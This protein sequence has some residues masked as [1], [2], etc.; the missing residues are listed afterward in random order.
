MPKIILAPNALKDSCTAATAAAAMARGIARALPDAELVQLPVADGGDGLAEVLTEVLDGEHRTFTVTGPRFTPVDA[1]LVWSPAHR[2]AVVE[3]A[4]AS[5]LALL[6]EHQRDATATTTLGTGE[7]MRAALD[8]GAK[9]IIVGLGGSA[10]NDGGVGMAQALG[11][12]FL[13]AAGQ[14]VEPMGSRLADIARIDATDKDPRLA[15]TRIEAVCDVDNPLTGS[16]GAARVYGPQKGAS[17]AQVDALDAGL[18]HLAGLIE[19]DLGLRISDLPGAGAAGGIGAG[20]AAFAGATLRPGAE[21]VLDL[22]E[23]D[24]HLAGAD[25]VLTAEGRID[26][27]TAHGKAPAAVAARAKAYGIPCIAI[28]GGIGDDIAALHAIGIDAVFSLCHGPMS[29]DAALANAQPLLADAAEQAVR[30]FFAGR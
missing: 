12:R 2:T 7:L 27:Q 17:Q 9:H 18:A 6:A 30:A 3:M 8:L 24:H 23:L 28:A 5:G 16:R 14:R 10:T 26:H 19:R 25:L 1:A 21:L 13:D 11:W 20:L 15:Q 22:L 4:L 29:L